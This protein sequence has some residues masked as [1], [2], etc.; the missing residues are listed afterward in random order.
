MVDARLARRKGAG[1]RFRGE[2][3]RLL[4][5]ILVLAETEHGGFG[6]TSPSPKETSAAA[7]KNPDRRR[8][9][10]QGHFHVKQNQ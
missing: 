4:K 9:P 6:R 2:D 3:A 10:A 8:K 5:E 1:S 7:D